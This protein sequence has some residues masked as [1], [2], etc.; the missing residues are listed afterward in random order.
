MVW[1]LI[2]WKQVQ[3]EGVGS[4]RKQEMLTILEHLSLHQYMTG[5]CVL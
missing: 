2:V 3:R 5:V 4:S 1:L